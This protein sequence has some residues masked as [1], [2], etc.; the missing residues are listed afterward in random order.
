MIIFPDPIQYIGLG[1]DSCSAAGRF[2]GL[3]ASQGQTAHNRLW[4]SFA[5]AWG[6]PIDMKIEP[7]RVYDQAGVDGKDRGNPG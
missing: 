7:S 1:S 2:G 5:W 3:R 4:K 6:P